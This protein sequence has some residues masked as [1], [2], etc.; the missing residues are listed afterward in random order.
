M[1]ACSK[2][3]VVKP[4]EAFTP[5]KKTKDRLQ[6]WCRECS[7]KHTKEHRANNIEWQERRREYM[8]TDKYKAWRKEYSQTE[9]GKAIRKNNKR[10][11]LLNPAVKRNYRLFYK[12]KAEHRCPLWVKP[13]ET[14]PFYQLAESLGDGYVVDHIIPL[15]GK[16]VSGLHVPANLQVLTVDAN[17]LKRNSENPIWHKV[18]LLPV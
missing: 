17:N 18:G 3:K 2:C 4:Y 7:N 15:R 6:S 8:R 1:K 11:H 9:I 10:Q 14:L 13:V 16:Y 12:L 5:N